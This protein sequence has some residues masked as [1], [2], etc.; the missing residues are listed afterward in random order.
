MNVKDVALV[1]PDDSTMQVAVKASV[2]DQL[3][4]LAASISA[5]RTRSAI[6]S[7]SI[8][9]LLDSLLGGLDTDPYSSSCRN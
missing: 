2:D 7:G 5:S 1:P 4:I 6:P 8:E 3:A 9:D